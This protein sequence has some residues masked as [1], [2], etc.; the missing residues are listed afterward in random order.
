M[1]THPGEPANPLHLSPSI[2]FTLELHL[3]PQH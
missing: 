2:G 3:S 1:A